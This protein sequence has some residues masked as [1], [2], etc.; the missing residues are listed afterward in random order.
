MLIT[1][2][3][4]GE[5]SEWAIRLRDEDVRLTPAKH[6]DTK[7]SSESP[8]LE[9]EVGWQFSAEIGDVESRHRKCQIVSRS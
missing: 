9:E 2:T 1:T 8:A 7:S 3:P 5:V 4:G 6:I